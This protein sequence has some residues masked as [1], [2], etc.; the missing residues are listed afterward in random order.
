MRHQSTSVRPV[1]RRKTSSSVE[2]RTSDGDRVEPAL[3]HLGQ[4]SPRRRRCRAAAG[5][6]APRPA[7]RGRRPGRRSAS[8][9]P[10][11]KRSSATSRV[12]CSRISCERRP[13]GHDQAAVHHHQP[14]AELLGLVHVVRGD[15]Q[16]HA[17]LLEP[18][19]PVPQQ[20]PGLRVEAGGRLVEQQQVGVVDQ[21]P[22]DR[23]PALHAAGEVV[24]LG[25]RLL[26]RAAR[27][28]AARRRGSRASALADAEVAAVDVEVVADVQLGVEGVLLRADAEPGADLPSR[29]S[30]GSQ[31]EDRAAR[32]R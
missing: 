18:E 12:E 29:A 1:S 4:R 28:R 24:D 5:R 31:A 10:T 2:R 30:A 13:L 16:R 6:A 23:Q 32:R 25:L 15:H 11:P 9:S 3:V 14:V 21:R 19:Q 17:L 22:G 27:T 26:G 7:R 20:V 8:C